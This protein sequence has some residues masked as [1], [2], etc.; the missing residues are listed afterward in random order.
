VFFYDFC[1]SY[2]SFETISLL[3]KQDTKLCLDKLWKINYVIFH[4]LYDFCLHLV[5][6][7]LH[8]TFCRIEGTDQ[9][10]FS[11]TDF[12]RLLRNSIFSSSTVPLLS[13]VKCSC[14]TLFR[15]DQIFFPFFYLASI[16]HHPN[17]WN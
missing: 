6:S 7:L 15:N 11:Y 13:W 12:S 17:Y 3:W 1:F 8:L 14:V 10:W 5:P 2:H 4:K 9:F 16:S